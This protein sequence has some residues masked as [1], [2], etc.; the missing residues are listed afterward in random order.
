MI[1]KCRNYIINYRNYNS[2]RFYSGKRTKPHTNVKSSIK[3]GFQKCDICDYIKYVLRYKRNCSKNIRVSH[4]ATGTI[5][6]N[7]SHTTSI[8][9]ISLSF[10][11]NLAFFPMETQRNQNIWHATLDTPNPNTT[12]LLLRSH[13]PPNYYLKP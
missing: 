7:A 6:H 1:A 8:T 2:L 10:S 4:R 9:S 12:K 13:I 5:L 11:R 3:Y